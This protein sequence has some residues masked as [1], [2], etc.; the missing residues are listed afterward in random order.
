M[1]YAFATIYIKYHSSLPSGR[2]SPALTIACE[3]HP[4]NNLRGDLPAKMGLDYKSLSAV[5][6]AIVCVHLSAYGRDNERAAW[7]GY[8]YLMQAEAGYLS[9]TGEPDGEPRRAA[10][11]VVDV[12][13]ALTAVKVGRPVAPPC[14]P[15]PTSS[16]L[17]STC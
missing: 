13:A 5:K 11:P 6:P 8:D 1:E 12:A 16:S 3:I 9:L 2:T 15:P 10:A 17:P 14:V 7:P 4:I